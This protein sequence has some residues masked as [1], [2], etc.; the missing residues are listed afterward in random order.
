MPDPESTQ[1]TE[2]EKQAEAAKQAEEEARKAQE[3]EENRPMSRKEL[4]E[5]LGQRD[6]ALL[7]AMREN[8]QALIAGLKPP[9][10]ERKEPE[11]PTKEEF[12]SDPIGSLNKFH[13]TKIA[14]LVAGAKTQP[15]STGL[16]ALVETQKL[17]LRQRIGEQNWQKY[18]NALLQVWSKT[19]PRVIAEPAGMDA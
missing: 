14:P 8:N 6:Q 10:A 9:A 3:A 11:M 13:E 12:W 1:Q 19:D 5:F 4:N 16:I 18:G 2:E 7:T 17:Q 15:D